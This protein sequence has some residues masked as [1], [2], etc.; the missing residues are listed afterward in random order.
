[1]RRK[2]DRDKG[3][4]MPN[5]LIIN[6]SIENNKYYQQFEVCT[7]NMVVMDQSNAQLARVLI[8]FASQTGNSEHLAVLLARDCKQYKVNYQ[9]INVEDYSVEALK[10]EKYIIFIWSTYGDGESTDSAKEFVLTLARCETMCLSKLNFCVFALG[11]KAYTN[12]CSAGVWLDQHLVSKGA[13]RICGM[14]FCDAG[15]RNTIE[16]QLDLWRV[17]MWLIF[18]NILNITLPQSELDTTSIDSELLIKVSKA[19]NTINKHPFLII[20]SGLPSTPKQPLLLRIKTSEK[21]YH[22]DTKIGHTLKTT[23]VL[24]LIYM[25]SLHAE[26]NTTS[27]S[28]LKLNYKAGDYLVIKPCNPNSLVQDYLS[29]IV[30]PTVGDVSLDVLDS[31]KL[32]ITNIITG[33]HFT[34]IELPLRSILTW[35]VDLTSRPTAYLIKILSNYCQHKKDKRALKRIIL[36]KSSGSSETLD[37]LINKSYN[38]LGI[39]KRFNIKIPLDIFLQ[40]FPSLAPRY[41]SIASD[42]TYY[43]KKV[44]I[45]VSVPKHGLCSNYLTKL[46]P[47]DTVYGY[48]ATSHFHL[49]KLLSTRQ[50]KTSN[51]PFILCICAGS[52]IAPFLGFLQ[53]L[54]VMQATNHTIPKLTLLFG[55]RYYS[56]MKPLIDILEQYVNHQ[57]IT[58]LWVALSRDLKLDDSSHKIFYYSN[59]YVQDVILKWK[60]KQVVDIII[61]TAHSDENEQIGSI[62][63]CG[64]AKGMATSVEQALVDALSIHQFNHSSEEAK[65]FL[66]VLTQR[67]KYLKDVWSNE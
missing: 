43:S 35:Y 3:T 4:I 56:E 44:A 32:H 58:E 57:C 48:I 54:Y 19:S 13:N 29:Y 67:N 8:L 49:N 46:E 61:P 10:D 59:C 16:K 12:F 1:M 28:S 24:K 51:V 37:E 17:D 42:S 34:P 7:N 64:D 38:A 65:T 63:V 22:S 33:K 39:L 14:G 40:V 20:P 25:E 31:N 9:L 50:V 62:Y 5:A 66:K 26:S 36:N 47:G 21:M 23:Q 30:N 11:D 55:C 18:A 53:E 52:G 15:S 6:D 60:S 41:Y 27:K 45:L 2:R